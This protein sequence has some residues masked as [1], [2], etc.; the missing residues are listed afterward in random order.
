MSHLLASLAGRKVFAKLN[1]AQAYQ[2][3]PV[4]EA[5]S[6]A[7]TIMTHCGAFRIKRLQFGVSVAPC[8]FQNLMEDVLK[9]LPGII[10]YFDDV[11]ITGESKAELASS[12]GPAP[13]PRRWLALR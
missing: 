5:T 11:L 13:F 3:L 9:D 4:D 8:L 12:R 6:E 7:Q 2:E 1:L 10:P